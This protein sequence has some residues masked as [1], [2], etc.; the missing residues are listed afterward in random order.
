MKSPFQVLRERGEDDFSCASV[1]KVLADDTRLG[2]VERLLD[3]PS[4]VTEINETLGVEST[5]LSHHLKALREAKLVTR[6]RQGR[7]AVYAL[8]PELLAR[9]K[10]R[11]VDLGCCKIS[12]S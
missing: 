1:L 9:R 4:T 3:G 10:G 11:S 12:F 8:A 5:L 2:V 6:T 7:Y